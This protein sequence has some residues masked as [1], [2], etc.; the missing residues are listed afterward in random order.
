MCVRQSRALFL[1][2]ISVK[3][4]NVHTYS[5]P[6]SLSTP[7]TLTWGSFMRLALSSANVLLWACTRKS[8]LSPLEGFAVPPFMNR[9]L[10]MISIVCQIVSL[11]PVVIAWIRIGYHF[12]RVLM[13]HW[14]SHYSICLWP[15]LLFLWKSILQSIFTIRISLIGCHDKERKMKP[16]NQ[17]HQLFDPP[18]AAV[19]LGEKVQI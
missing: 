19:T 13:V 7:K 18:T 12:V 16:K 5:P 11:I 8:P 10:P 14:F 3:S 4:K 9:E 17:I 6:Q 15:G 1:S 2:E